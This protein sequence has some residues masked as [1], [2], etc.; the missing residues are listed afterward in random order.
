MAAQSTNDTLNN[1]SSDVIADTHASVEHG[2]SGLPQLEFQ[3]W[4]GQIGY[5]LI[6]FVVL[7]VLVAKV[8][9]PRLRKVMDERAETI[10]SAVAAAR[11]VQTEAAAQAEAA[12]AE[13]EKARADARATAVA[14]KQRVTEEFNAR[15][16]ADEAVVNARIAEAEGA[17][18]KTR[19]AAMANVTII[20]SDAAG[21]MLE[22]LTGSK[23]SDAELAAAIKGAA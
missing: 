17:I 22:R 10:D 8:F 12:R 2:S 20:A 3:H 11:S 23:A 14:A 19:D 18:A 21:A 16:A 5:L 9:A 1:V 15:L 7:Y 4:A 6:L 13:V